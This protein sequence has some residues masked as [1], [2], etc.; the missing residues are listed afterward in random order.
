M[1][2]CKSAR[3]AGSR[4]LFKL[5]DCKYRTCWIQMACTSVPACFSQGGRS[6]IGC[7]SPAFR[8][9]FACEWNAELTI[10]KRVIGIFR[11][12]F[13]CFAKLAFSEDLNRGD[14]EDK[15]V[16]GPGK[17]IPVAGVFRIKCKS[18][19]VMFLPLRSAS[20]R[21]GGEI[22]CL[23]SKSARNKRAKRPASDEDSSDR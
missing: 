19:T 22:A 5:T 6:G 12:R 9:R 14:A 4:F 2:Q 20:R 3:C 11:L 18:L 1:Y 13:A 17:Q 21:L 10:S 7:V 15:R 16:Q 8:P 23:F